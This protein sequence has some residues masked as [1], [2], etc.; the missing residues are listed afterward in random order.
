MNNREYIKKI[1]PKN[2][3]ILEFGPLNIPIADK[4]TFKNVKYADIKTTEEIKK[5]Y[6]GNEYLKN[7]GIYVDIDTIVDIDYVVKKD[8]KTDIKEKFD[9]VILSHVIEH[10][11]NILHF[12]EDV[13][14]IL[15][16]DGLL[17]INY[18]DRRYCF[19]HYRQESTFVDAYLVYTNQMSNDKMIMDFYMNVVKENNP[20]VFWYE[21]SI[22][23]KMNDKEKD[24][25]LKNL[26]KKN[27]D[28]KF[29]DIHYWPFSDYGFLKFLDDA[30]R[31]KLMNF[32]IEEFIE[33][34]ENTQEFLTIF[35]KCKFKNDNLRS[36]IDKLDPNCKSTLL[37][38]K[39]KKELEEGRRN[40]S[41]K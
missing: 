41:I 29:E 36:Y 18:P 37:R 39:Y 12:F 5:M 33:T 35:K 28:G 20:F 23:S 38:E 32:K 24:E 21:T 22:S 14:N 6:S 19:D 30:R 31:F 7:T 13:Q 8:Y 9:I 16:D 1:I 11:P 15:N 27:K 26:D 40:K 34:Q 10:M 25:I 17:I 3:K 4:N 2:K